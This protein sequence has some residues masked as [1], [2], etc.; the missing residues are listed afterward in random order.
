ML[1]PRRGKILKSIVG[2]YII[3][4]A[5]VA[6]QYIVSDRE[7]Q[8]SSATIRNEMAQ[9]EAEGYIIR[10]HSSAGSIPS[11]KGYRYYVESL[12]KIEL[13]LNEQRMISHLFHQVEKEL[14]EWLKL[15]AKLLAQLVNNMAVVSMP[16]TMQV[17]YKFLDLI[18]LH[19]LSALLIFVMH[20]ARIKQRL[21]T[22]GQAT[23]QSQLTDIAN[24]LNGIYSGLTRT[25]IMSLSPEL[26]PVEKQLTEYL[27]KIMETEGNRDY[28]EPYLNGLHLILSQPEFNNA[29]QMKA[30]MELVDQRNLLNIIIPIGPASQEIRVVIGKENKEETFQDYSLVI[31]HYGLP[32]ATGTIGVIGPT[33][34]P[35]ARAISTVSYLST[36][37]SRLAIELYGKEAG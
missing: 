33:R 17:R 31:G 14:E 8:V 7:L 2:Q 27:L 36:I 23:S 5:P 32:E 16:R 6:S 18:S 12:N 26:S 10:Q 21:T 30:L 24:R 35:Y 4:A 28:E 25:E 37:L 11:D 3:K 29:R 34:M 15:A 13:P 19:S 9:L 20:G 22:F 1:S